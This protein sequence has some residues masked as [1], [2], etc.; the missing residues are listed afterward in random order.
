MAASV[1]IASPIPKRVSDWMLRSSAETTPT[2]SD[3]SSPNGLPIAATGS[4][5]A[6]PLERPRGS[7]VRSKPRRVDLQQR[8][9]RVRVGADDLRRHAVAVR[10]LDEHPLRRRS[11]LSPSV[12]TTWAFVAM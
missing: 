3:C 7:G 6:S 11:E 8:H 2:D 9:V 5:T 1:W 10:E 12:V 4:P